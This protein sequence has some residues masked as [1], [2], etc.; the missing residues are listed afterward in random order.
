MRV[1]RVKKNTLE[2][3]LYNIVDTLWH[4]NL[5]PSTHNWKGVEL[6]SENTQIDGARE[7]EKKMERERNA[8]RWAYFFLFSLLKKIIFLL[9]SALCVR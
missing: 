3:T 4:G 2:A 6:H 9:S 8:C 5:T 7:K 1:R